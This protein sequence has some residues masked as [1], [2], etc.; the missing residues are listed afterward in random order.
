MYDGTQYRGFGQAIVEELAAYAGVPVFNG[1]T[2]EFHP[3]QM[4]ADVLTMR[5]HSQSRSTKSLMLMWA[6]PAPIWAIRCC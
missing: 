1:L 3:T 2:N 6:M 5:E 4:L